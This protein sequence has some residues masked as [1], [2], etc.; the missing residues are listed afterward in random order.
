MS[1]AHTP[2]LVTHPLPPICDAQSRVLLLGSMPSPLS[3]ANGFH[4]GNPQNRFWRV[5]SLLWEEDLP[6][7]NEERSLFCARHH[8]ALDD[9]LLQC[10]IVGASDASISDP[11][12]NDLS[13]ILDI[14]PITTIFCTGSTA[15]KLYHRFIEPNVH[16]KAGQ[17]PSTT[18]ANARMRLPELVDRWQV[19]R[20]AADSLRQDCDT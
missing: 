17:L 4:Y 11:V 10:K 19:V 12:P 3:R 16:M 5:L 20:E 2:Q 18:P 13:R 8:L 6:Q 15:W 7:T 14:A 9:V 1:E